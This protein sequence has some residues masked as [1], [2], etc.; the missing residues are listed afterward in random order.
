MLDIPLT[1]SQR[2]L[3]GLDPNAVTTP[4]VAGQQY[5]TPPRYQRA[6][7]GSGSPL[8]GRRSGTGSPLSGAATPEANRRRSSVGLNSRWLYQKGK[9]SDKAIYLP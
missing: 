8:G 2:A 7:Y 3:L 5:V 4:L 6:P 9:T 1:P